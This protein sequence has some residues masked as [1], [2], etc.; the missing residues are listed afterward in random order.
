MGTPEVAVPPL[1]AL[2]AAGFDIALVVSRADKRR[3]R[4]G[5]L[6]PSPVKAAA[7][8]LGIPVTTTIADAVDVGADLGVVVAFG[9][10][11][12]PEVLDQ[13]AMVNL[14][15]SLLPRWRGAAPVE[16]AILAGDAITGVCLMALSEEL[17]TGD[18]YRVHE[19][20]IREQ[21]LPELRSQLVDIG[22]AMLV[23]ALRTGL[24]DPTPQAGDPVYAYKI[25]TD[26]LRL[27]FTKSA[28]QL[29]RVIRMGNAWTTALGKRLKV[30]DATVAKRSDTLGPGQVDGTYVGTGTNVVELIEVQP[31]GKPRRNAKDWANGVRF[32]E[33]ERL[34]S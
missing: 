19:V 27:D 22:S 18:I 28:D 24:G 6:S 30:W 15:F 13:L 5:D 17:D 4:G 9:R 20:P 29:L 25:T 3:G 8:E 14:H 1:R 16:R 32:A 31:E 23:D 12:Q 10:L 11:I 7:L 2:H 26:D 21:S 34:G 33:N